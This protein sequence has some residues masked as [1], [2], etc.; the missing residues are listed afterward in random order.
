MKNEISLELIDVSRSFG[1]KPIFN[2]ISVTVRGGEAL[3]VLG[4]S[5]MGKTT[6]L[7]I[8]GTIDR[9]SNGKVYICGKDIPQ[10]TNEELADLRY[11]RIGYSFQEP[12]LLSGISALENVLLPCYPRV[13][14]KALKEFR[15]KAI[16]IL[17]EMK[18]SDR[19]TYRPHQLSLG[20]KKR[21]DMARALINDPSILILDEPTTNLDSESASIIREMAKK[22]IDDGRVLVVTTHQDEKL[23]D[24]AKLHIRIQDYQNY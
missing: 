17:T 24:L 19:I 8:M 23:L 9:P 6:L 3:A 10:L 4:P 20:Q 14:D 16:R 1:T 5:G 11:S 22:V 2:N 18:L 12:T 15:E 13:K 7:R 21:V